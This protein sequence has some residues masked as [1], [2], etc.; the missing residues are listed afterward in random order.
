[1]NAF[2]TSRPLPRL[3]RTVLIVLA[4][5]GLLANG[6]AQTTSPASAALP[7]IRTLGT[8]DFAQ[9]VQR[10]GPAVVNISVSGT[11]LVT[12]DGKDGATNSK[13]SDGDDP[14]Q[15]FLRKFQEQFGATGA[16]MQIPVSGRASG[17][18]VSAD[19]L[20][21]TNAHVIAHASEVIVKL[22]DRR[23]F[24]AKVLGSDAKTD[25]AVLKIEARNLP[26][27]AIGKPADLSVG[28]WVLAI[29][30][31]F[32]LDN[33]VTTGVV[34]AKSRTLPDDYT[35]PFIQTDAAINPGNS[36]GPLFNARGEVVGINSQIY[37]RSGG[38][39]GLSFAIPIDLAQSVQR[40]IVATGHASHG[41][42]GVS[43][44]E[45]TQ[46]LADAFKLPKPM[47]ALIAEV[48]P[49]SAATKAGLLLGDVIVGI[50]GHPIETSNDLP[51]WVAMAVPGQQVQVDVLRNGK[52]VQTRATMDDPALRKPVTNAT[53][54]VPVLVPIGLAVRPLLPVEQRAAD[55]RYGLMVEGVQPEAD[56]AGI[57]PGDILLAINQVPVT[58]VEQARAL[59]MQ[60]K[61][62]VALL[63]QHGS[64]KSFLAMNLKAGV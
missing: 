23:E 10:Y 20:V 13:S 26:T 15:L 55:T 39:Q 43:A 53:P 9:I 32:G 27:V 47:G 50:D 29:G 5:A 3:A 36:G 8:P 54:N 51:L 30:S 11:R 31:P 17:F 4:S 19:G 56:K 62:S 64:D 25:V 61:G 58:S 44:Q 12:A 46:A 57:A 6:H 34:S 37:T 40:Q 63:V 16:S 41:V 35:V 48:R 33:T 14:T 7:T 42:L 38:Y 22:T 28:E 2:A 49:D 60:A 45:V 24:T 1:M 52:P 21:L 18:I 59:L